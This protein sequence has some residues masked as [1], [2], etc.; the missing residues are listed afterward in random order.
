[1]ATG[2]YPYW[3]GNDESLVTC[4]PK[5]VPAPGTYDFV[6]VVPVDFS[7]DFEEAPTPKQL[8]ERAENYMTANK[9]GVPVVKITA[10]FVQLEQSEEYKGIS[11][12]LIHILKSRAL[13]TACRKRL[14]PDRQQVNLR[15][16]W[17]A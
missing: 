13:P 6:R 7:E 14:R 17:T 10:S 12:S 9:V 4:D 2:I 11:L 1:M 3:V 8:R 5:I 15:S 16:F